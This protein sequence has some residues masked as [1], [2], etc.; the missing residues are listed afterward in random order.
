[1]YNINI[2]VLYIYACIYIYIVC[3][4]VC[5]CVCVYCGGVHAGMPYCYCKSAVVMRPSDILV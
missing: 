3:V 2:Y 5:V 4:C 1:M